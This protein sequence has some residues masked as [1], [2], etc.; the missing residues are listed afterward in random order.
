MKLK[1]GQV[2]V[3]ENGRY[4]AVVSYNPLTSLYRGEYNGIGYMY[5]SDGVYLGT[6]E[7][8]DDMNIVRRL[9]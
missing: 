1:V 3:T 9:K 6:S 7:V 8:Y 5:H 4:M 2:Y